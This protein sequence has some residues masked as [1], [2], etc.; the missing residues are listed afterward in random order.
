MSRPNGLPDRREHD[1]LL[2][3][4]DEM[5]E[6]QSAH[7]D[8]QLADSRAHF[9]ARLTGIEQKVDPMFE[10][11]TTGKVGWKIVVAVAGLAAALVGI[12]VGI[13]QA[14]KGFR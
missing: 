9:D 4:I 3:H 11:F 2:N 6:R 12:A 10:V 8:R 7:F 1:S 13:W 5:L 14:W